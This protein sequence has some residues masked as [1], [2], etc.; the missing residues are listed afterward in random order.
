MEAPGTF[1]PGVS[2]FQSEC[3]AFVPG[4]P[5]QRFEPVLFG[6]RTMYT[7]MRLVTD[8]STNSSTN[9]LAGVARVRAEANLIIDQLER[10][11]VGKR[12]V[13]ERAVTAL[14]CEGHVLLEDVPGVGKTVLAR[15][16]AA[17]IGGT[18]QRIQ[19]T[20][21]LLPSDVTG[22]LV[23][24]PRTSEFS[25]RPGPIVA[26]VVLADEINRAGPRT[27]AALL[28][29]MEERHVTVDRERKALPRPFF[30]IATQNPVEMDGTFPLPEAQLDRF[31]LRTSIGYPAETDEIAMLQ[32][33]RTE[34]PLEQLT[35][36]TGP[37]ALTELIGIVRGVL[38]GEAVERY[39]IALVR[40]TRE[41]DQISMGV[42]PRG[43]LAL[44]RA[45]Q[46]TA[47]LAGRDY[48]LPDD[49]QAMAVP[50][51]AHRILPAA[52]FGLR[53]LSSEA[54]IRDIA[55]KVPAPVEAPAT[56]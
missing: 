56:I 34:S 47:A 2:L 36:I 39:L 7:G 26:N 8:L 9:A 30:V 14:L 16:L 17:T 43:S 20:P 32:R 33:F 53:G 28:E 55:G 1:V 49:V 54:L 25:Y 12:D 35:P 48:V 4:G 37:E 51:L 46:A 13:L 6:K 10:V 15:S 40:A 23:F 38:I 52:T 50:V 5:V 11:I 45:A 27:Q 31:F 29:A 41:H 18:F 42:S 22:S 24:D 3:T 19:F 44:A 21:D